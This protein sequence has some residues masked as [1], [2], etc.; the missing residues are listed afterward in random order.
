MDKTAGGEVDFPPKMR[1]QVISGSLLGD[2]LGAD[3][4]LTFQE[5][6]YLAS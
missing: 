3:K 5:F 1:Q 4:T 2:T 6:N